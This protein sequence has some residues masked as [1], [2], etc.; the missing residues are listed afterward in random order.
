MN[1]SY[2]Y[3]SKSRSTGLYKNWTCLCLYKVLSKSDTITQKIGE[4]FSNYI[5][6]V[7][8]VYNIYGNHNNKKTRQFNF[9]S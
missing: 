8:L 7:E 6:V 3:K 1:L 9:S 2:D 4:R 5:S